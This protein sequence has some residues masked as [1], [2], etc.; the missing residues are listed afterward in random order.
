MTSIAERYEIDIADAKRIWAD[1][2]ATME[3]EGMPTRHLVTI[4]INRF[5]ASLMI[6]D[7]PQRFAIDRDGLLREMIHD[8]KGKS[9]RYVAERLAILHHFLN[10]LVQAGL[11][12]TNLL[13]EFRIGF[14]KPSWHHVVQALQSAEPE[15][16]L[17]SLRKPAPLL[18]PLAIYVRSYIDLQQ[19]LGK[20]YTGQRIAL[21]DLD[22]YLQT[23][24]VSSPQAIERTM[25]ESWASTLTC[26]ARV[27]IHKARFARR[28]FDYLRS[29]SVV[30]HNPV[31]RTLTSRDRLPRSSFKPFIFTKEQLAAML[32]KAKQLAETPKIRCR[33]PHT[34]FTMLALLSA[35]GLRHGE[36]RRLRIRDL[37]LAQQTLFIN[38]TKFHKS[39]SVPFG[40]N[41]GQCLTRYLEIRRTL[42]QPVHEDDPLFATKWRKPISPAT[43]LNVF[44][45]IL[46]SL[47]IAD[48]PGQPRCTC[49]SPASKS[50]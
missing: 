43:L 21:Y 22:R 18:G 15:K 19:S 41:V 30:T 8:A 24:G 3:G 28:F 38:Q 17:A 35:L 45:G 1:H 4:T 11:M 47:G 13:A 50:T 34:Y 29:L 10:A 25:I 31:P 33:A 27:R 26:I 14:G 20:N 36:A 40:A 6:P 23:Q 7:K 39:R 42:L 5:L 12:G 32:D 9:I 46:D 16:N 37:D 2:L 44:R 49:S 48:V